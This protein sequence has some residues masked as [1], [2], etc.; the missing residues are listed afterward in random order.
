M[1]SFAALGRV[2]KCFLVL[3]WVVTLKA[4]YFELAHARLGDDLQ[5][6]GA[7]TLTHAPR[8][9]PTIANLRVRDESRARIRLTALEKHTAPFGVFGHSD[10]RK[11]KVT[12]VFW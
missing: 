6:V 8:V 9:R 3:T 4:A 5:Y 1:N 2:Q 10:N 7:A 11:E 12:V